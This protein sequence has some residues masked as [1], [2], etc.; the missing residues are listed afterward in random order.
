MGQKD[1]SGPVDSW[2]FIGAGAG[3]P[4]YGAFAGPDI[5]ISGVLASAGPLPGNRGWT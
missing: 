1:V 5:L 2:Y 4:K 3:D